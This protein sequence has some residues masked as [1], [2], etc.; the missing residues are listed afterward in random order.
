MAHKHR[1]GATP[2]SGCVPVT[3]TGVEPNKYF[4]IQQIRCQAERTARSP[5]EKPKEV[6][7]V[8]GVTLARCR[9]RIYFLN[10]FRV[11]VLHFTA[12]LRVPSR[13]GRQVSSVDDPGGSVGGIQIHIRVF[14]HLIFPRGS[15]SDCMAWAWSTVAL[16]L[17]Q[18]KARPANQKS[19]AGKSQP[20][21]QQH[22]QH[23]RI[24]RS[25]SAHDRLRMLGAEE[26]N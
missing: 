25:A 13:D 20:I 9:R 14:A 6:Q 22:M 3:R 10:L 18:T 7:M 16:Q 19:E 12:K 5:S 21:D 8:A 11:E 23:P 26:P 24:D 1:C 4:Y 17:F 2:F 15:V